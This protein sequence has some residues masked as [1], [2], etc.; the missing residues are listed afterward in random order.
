MDLTV[1]DKSSKMTPLLVKLYDSH[2]INGLAKDK[3]PGARAELTS[4]IAE[5]LEMNLSPRESEL[6]ADVLMS[7]TRQAERDLRCALSEKL[8]LMDNVPLRLI[9][10]LAN[11][12]IEI[13]SP[14][15][16]KS[17]VLTDLDLIYLIKSKGAEHWRAIAQR[18]KMNDQI[19]NILVD[20]GENGTVKTLIE[21]TEI[22]LS[23]YAL[24]VVTDMACKDEVLA[25]PLL[26]REEVTLDIAKRIYQHVGKALRSFIVEAY[27]LDT[28]GS[29]VDMVDDVIEEFIEAA[30]AIP[31][32]APTSASMKDA[33][34]YLEKGLLTM[35]MMLGTLRRGQIKSFIAQFAKY[36]G[37]SSET[38]TDVLTQNSGQGLAVTCRAFDIVKA[39]FMSIFLLT[40]R[41]RNAGKMVDLKDMDK[42]MNY[43]RR[44]DKKVA[45]DIVKNSLQKTL[46]NED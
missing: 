30:D 36:T 41:I 20:T 5:L 35:S 39:D 28:E 13:A 12:E 14:I 16:R 4:I 38:V 21:N 11:D 32:L 46:S 6:A 7:L 3:Q 44:V 37:M 26:Q 23:E 40:H 42:A 34:R 8:A 31:D 2:K 27:D 24:D 15:L 43:Y 9:L 22:T 18:P 29:I 25:K 33:D 45:E 1:L 10:L 19:I 17:D